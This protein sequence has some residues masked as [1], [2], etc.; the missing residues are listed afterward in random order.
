MLDASPFAAKSK[1]DKEKTPPP[2]NAE[3]KPIV[4]WTTV[5]RT[6]IK[7]GYR[8]SKNLRGVELTW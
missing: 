4:G 1:L 5:H 3:L 8:I 7:G 2:K 6:G